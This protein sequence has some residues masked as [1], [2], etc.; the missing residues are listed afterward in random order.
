VIWLRIIE[1]L[2]SIM[3]LAYFIVWHEMIQ[4]SDEF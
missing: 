2:L 1:S 3:S 4:R